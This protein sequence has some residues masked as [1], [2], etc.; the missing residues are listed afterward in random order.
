MFMVNLK[1]KIMS[2][3]SKIQKEQR[4]KFNKDFESVVK[5][6][7]N[8]AIVNLIIKGHFQSGKLCDSFYYKKISDME[9]EIGNT[10]PYARYLE[11]GTRP[12]YIYSQTGKNLVFETKTFQKWNNYLSRPIIGRDGGFLKI[13]QLV[14]HP[15]IDA[16]WFLLD[17]IQ[18][19]WKKFKTKYN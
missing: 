6:I 13:T 8:D 10:A 3:V 11:E 7:I 4:A 17:S 18:D 15:G 5:D 19:N 12:H 9:Y 14:S 2:D 16:E 1:D